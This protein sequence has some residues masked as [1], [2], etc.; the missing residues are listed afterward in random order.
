MNKF[1]NIFYKNKY[2]VGY[3]DKNLYC[4]NSQNK[5]ILWKY[6]TGGAVNS[7]VIDKVLDYIYFGSLDGKIYA[8]DFNGKL[9]W[10]KHLGNVKTAPLLTENNIPLL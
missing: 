5:K 2:F 3:D 10:K 8:S 7:L 6:K 4:I 9:I 1:F